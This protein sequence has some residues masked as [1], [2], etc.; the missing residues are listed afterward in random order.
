MHTRDIYDILKSSLDNRDVTP[1]H[2]VKFTYYHSNHHN[3]LILTWP[4][5]PMLKVQL[6]YKHTKYIWQHICIIII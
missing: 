4:R 3:S 5:G 6:V 2:A 1:K